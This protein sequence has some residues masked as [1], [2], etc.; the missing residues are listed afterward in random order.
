MKVERSAFVCPICKNALFRVN[1]SLRCYFGHSFDLAKQGYVNLLMKNS[2]GK[3]H[4]DDKLMVLAR[5]NFLDK[6]YY[7]PLRDTVSRI[8]GKGHFVLDSGCGEGYYTSAFAEDNTVC[9]IDISKDAV[10]YAAN[11]CKTAEFAVASIADIPLPDASCDTVVCIFAPESIEEFSRI[12]KPNGRMI[13]VSPMEKHLLELKQ[14]IYDDAYLNPAVTFDR[15]YFELVEATELKYRITLD[16]SED[17]KALFM[18]T[19]YYYKTAAS[20]QQKLERIE[21]LT[22]SLEF[23]VAEYKKQ[24]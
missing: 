22:T 7:A 15:E 16:T 17:I 19:P 11:R 8:V 24:V 10:Q 4:G 23:V 14:A 1:N 12:L 13:T 3:R 20:D 5:K 9:G 2:S 21:K 6:G 18:M